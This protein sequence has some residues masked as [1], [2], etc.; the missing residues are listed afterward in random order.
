M[1]KVLITGAGGFIGSH[2]AKRLAEK[3]EEVTCLVRPAS[4]AERLA[5]SRVR[6]SYGDICVPSEME[7]VLDNLKIDII[8]HLAGRTC[9]KNLEQFLEV[10]QGGTENL[11]HA[12]TK[13]CPKPPVLIYVSSLAVMGPSQSGELKRETEIPE[14]I[15]R[16]G[17]SKLAAEHVLVSVSDRI[18]V[19]VV[20]P[21]IV[22]GDTDL[23]NLELFRTIQK[24]G[25]CPI[26][27]WN[28]KRYSWIHVEDLVELLLLAAESGERLQPDS[29]TPKNCGYGVYFGVTVE[30]LRLS[31]L[32]QE[33]GHA[34]GR[35]RTLTLRCPPLVVLAVSSYYEFLKRTT[36]KDQPFDWDKA[37]EARHN[38]VCCGQKA[39]EQFHFAPQCSFADRIHQTVRWYQENGLLEPEF[40]CT[41]NASAS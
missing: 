34:L 14:P 24:T 39:R 1:K 13:K 25:L 18:P 20:R 37:V 2:L 9:A 31:E 4:S 8:F 7:S 29:L 40:S 15:S 6:L 30:T 19:T 28:D 32:G 5:D 17:K 16:Y 12:V 10:N 26:P 3:G 21:G 22:F 36:G 27:G 23:M 38:W 41:G 33:V 11:I 35:K